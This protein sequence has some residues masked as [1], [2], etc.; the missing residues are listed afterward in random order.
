MRKIL[1]L[2]ALV[3]GIAG[4]GPMLQDWCVVG[5]QTCTSPYNH[6]ITATGSYVLN[7]QNSLKA[8]PVNL[9]RVGANDT[10]TA[11]LAN[12]NGAAVSDV[13]T[14]N[15]GSSGYVTGGGIK[16]YWML[17]GQWQLIVTKCVGRLIATVEQ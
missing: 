9:T 3:A 12:A 14:I 2:L 10:I 17:G 13:M 15:S 16:R 5:T 11:Y 1:T 8:F 4:A 6:Y 7:Q